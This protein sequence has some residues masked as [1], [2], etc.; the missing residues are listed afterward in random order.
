MLAALSV[1]RRFEDRT[2]HH[3][4]VADPLTW[5]SNVLAPYLQEE[6]RG[7]Q[8]DL[9]EIRLAV[10]QYAQQL[11]GLL[12]RRGA[13]APSSVTAM[14]AADTPHNV[15]ARGQA[16][17]SGGASATVHVSTNHQG[18]ANSQEHDDTRAAAAAVP[19]PLKQP[20]YIYPRPPPPGFDAWL[21]FAKERQCELQQY[22]QIES[23]LAAFRDL[24][25]SNK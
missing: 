15:G 8:E 14:Q 21:A 18:K 10:R 11:P 3:D 22:D 24:S 16:E 25:H 4:Q 23:D 9:Q 5:C 12:G 17:E 7:L 13:M 19:A 20:L 6:A 1:H 2:S